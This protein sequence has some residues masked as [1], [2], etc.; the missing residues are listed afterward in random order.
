MGTLS[1]FARRARTLIIGGARSVE[2]PELF[3]KMSLVALLAWVGLGADGLTSSAY[4]PEEAFLALGAR[5]PLG[6]FVAAATA[7]TIFIIAAS[8]S[9]IV[10]V[11]P[12]GGGGYLVASK[13]LTPGLG[14]ASGCALLVDYVLTISLSIAAGAD[15]LFSSLPAYLQPY[16][17]VTAAAAILLLMVLNLRGVRESVMSLTPIF[18]L[19]LI[20]HVVAI[21]YP[22]VV[23]LPRLGDYAARTVTEVNVGVS[24]LG[25]LGVVFLILRAYS[26]GAG[27]FTGIEA[28]S[29]AMPI[30]REPRV[31][32]AKKTMRYMAVS[33]AFMAAGLMVGY[34][35]YDV[36]SEAGRTLNATLFNRIIEGWGPLGPLF[37]TVTL[38][39]EA[40]FLF[41]AAQTGF[42]SAPRVLSYMSM[43]RWFPQQFSLLSER[44][45]IKNGLALTGIAA[46]LTLILT[47]GSVRFMVVLYS[48]NVFITFTL[49]QLGMV[50]HWL[51]SRGDNP[52]WRKKIAVNGVGLVLTLF[53]LVSMIVL[54]FGDGGWITIFVTGALML[55]AVSINNFYRRTQKQLTHLDGLVQVV[56]ATRTENHRGTAGRRRRPR[57]NAKAR[58]AVILVSG[59]NG[60]GLHPLFNV[61]RLFGK[62]VKNFFFIQAG[63]IDAE[64]F[65]GKD[66]LERLESHVQESLDKYV[67]YVRNQGFYARGL[68]LVA[69]DVVDGI[70]SLALEVFREHPNSIFFGGR[71]VFREETILTRMLY[72]YVTFAVQRRL[73]QNGIPFVIVPVPVS[74]DL[75]PG[76]R[77]M[78]ARAESTYRPTVAAAEA[79]EP[80]TAPRGSSS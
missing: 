63:I 17:L 2:D 32:T 44:F 53:I 8:Y 66:E 16:K 9:Q 10:E 25:T 11:F 71:I 39:S 62:G 14:M 65:K 1:D 52:A 57:Y 78:L 51:R 46:L 42:L 18:L 22:L 4:G 12:G 70:S 59:F 28:V 49:S 30:L 23:H 60:M 55:V 76:S 64:S 74:A 73:H 5:V 68:P 31:A 38:L 75:M 40:V 69:T 79:P 54:K 43:D 47:G 20:T 35:L 48:I 37:V 26:M 61:V 80:S 72:N 27:T 36:K 7:I 41:A 77:P 21:V 6:I 19:F 50:R 58:T 34:I 45:V 29:N 33:L 15:A 56:E 3:K 67:D 13:L 24:G